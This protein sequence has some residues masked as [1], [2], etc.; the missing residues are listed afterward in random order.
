MCRK[1]I[2][3]LV[4][5]VFA[6]KGFSQQAEI[7][8][9]IPSSAPAF[10]V[11]GISPTE[12]SKPNSWNALQAAFYQNLA[13]SDGA[14]PKNFALEFSPYW[15]V[16]HPNFTYNNYLDQN[17]F[18]LRNLAFSVASARVP[19]S[20]DTA[21]SIGFGFRLPITIGNKKRTKIKSDLQTALTQVEAKLNWQSDFSYFIGSFN[22]ATVGDFLTQITTNLATPPAGEV[23]WIKYKV[24]I[25]KLLSDTLIT[26]L[27]PVKAQ[28]YA[29]NK[30]QIMT[31]VADYISNYNQPLAQA[32]ATTISTA[33]KEMS[34]WEI[35]GALALAFPTDQFDY[36]KFSQAAI[37]TDYTMK[38][39]E[40]SPIDGTAALRYVRTF[41]TT[42]A[43][44]SSNFDL[45]YRLNYAAGANQKFMISLW[46]VLRSKSN[47]L[48]KVVVN[49]VTYSAAKNTW[50]NKFGA[51]ISYKLSNNFALSYSL[52]KD[53]KN[54]L[55][56]IAGQTSN[57]LISFLNIFYSLNTK[58]QKTGKDYTFKGL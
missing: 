42:V 19:Y 28:T 14:A 39:G 26:S 58:I 38:F 43:S 5:S 47:D 24:E 10:T 50:D 21:Q 11:L 44:A 20:A 45:I 31:I 17:G 52:G 8:S 16:S 54:P 51:D 56:N 27:T 30:V 7:S 36:S 34:N 46:G 53:Y 25:G 12:I 4:V 40:K 2:L 57:K 33:I 18:S 22:G 41:E 23:L 9:I 6:T 29:A 55:G 35:S 32:T 15:L 49:N 1:L 37:W 48:P 3:L 13:S